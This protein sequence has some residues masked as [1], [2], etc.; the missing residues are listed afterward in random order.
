MDDTLGKMKANL[1]SL[2]MEVRKKHFVPSWM[3]PEQKQHASIGSIYTWCCGWNSA[4][5]KVVSK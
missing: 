4:K 2:L 5:K 3:Q 1:E